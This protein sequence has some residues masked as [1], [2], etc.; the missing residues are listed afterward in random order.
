MTE[1]QKCTE[2]LSAV[3][4]N[5]LTQ[6]E[7]NDR[8]V[9]SFAGHRRKIR[10]AWNRIITNPSEYTGNQVDSALTKKMIS[11]IKK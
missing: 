5:D 3:K 1:Q 8:W 9:G 7:F 6:Q 10:K 11:T 4:R 2:A